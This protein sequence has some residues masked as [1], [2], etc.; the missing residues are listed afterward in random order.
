MTGRGQCGHEQDRHRPVQGM[1]SGGPPSRTQRRHHPMP[2]HRM[3][4][5]QDTMQSVARLHARQTPQQCRARPHHPMVQ[6]WRRHRRER[7]RH[8]PPMQPVARQRHT[9]SSSQDAMQT[10]EQR[11]DQRVRTMVTPTTTATVFAEKA[12]HKLTTDEKCYRERRRSHSD[13]AQRRANIRSTN[14]KPRHRRTPPRKVEGGK[15]LP[16]PPRSHPRHSAF[17]PRFFPRAALRG[18]SGA[19]GCLLWRLRVALVEVLR[20]RFPKPSRCGGW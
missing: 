2:M 15:T 10:R 8:L 19:R 7:T 5:M 11:M 18:L 3:P 1:A 14:P 17:S 20:C 12:L 4:S 16:S 13:T 6:G 9:P